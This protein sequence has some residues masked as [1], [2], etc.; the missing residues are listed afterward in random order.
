MSY[1]IQYLGGYLDTNLTFSKHVKQN[2]KAAMAN[3]VKIQSI[4][5]YLLVS[6]CTTL[7]L[8]PCILHIEYAN[9]MLY[10]TTEKVLN[11]YQALQNMCAKLVLG[12]SKYDSTSQVLQKL[13]WLLV[14][15]RICHK[16]LKL[17]HKS[18]YR[19]APE[20][21]KN[22]IEINGKQIRNMCSNENGL[23][24]RRPYIKHQLLHHIHS[25]MLHQHCGMDCHYT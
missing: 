1:S 6:T 23:L 24:I 12:K 2:V 16:I 18:I 19:Q 20:Y 7:V 25:N 4:R 5:K 3:F 22:L 13:H 10:G 14:Q 11:K 8:M 15:K 17:T 21:L 9:A